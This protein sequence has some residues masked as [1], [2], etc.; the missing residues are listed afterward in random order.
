MI[1]YAGK[2][3]AT[4]LE[5]EFMALARARPCCCCIQFGIKRR[6]ILHHLK[7]G[8][9]RMGDRFV[10]PLCEGHHVGEF[11][12]GKQYGLNYSVH[13]DRYR[14]IESFG[15]EK[16]LWEKEQIAM[17]LPTTGWPI[18]KILPRRF[19]LQGDGEIL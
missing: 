11:E 14:F 17:G 2:K 12:D 15:S 13:R 8:G 3:P 19:P 9:R 6:A 18:S 16:E 7:D 1:A 4:K 10:I 5:R